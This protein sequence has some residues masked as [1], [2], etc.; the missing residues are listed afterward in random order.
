MPGNSYREQFTRIAEELEQS[1]AGAGKPLLGK[2][3]S[4]ANED[5]IVSALTEIITALGG[6]IA[7]G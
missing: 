7:H 4:L 2:S 3:Y 5:A 1:A 6:E